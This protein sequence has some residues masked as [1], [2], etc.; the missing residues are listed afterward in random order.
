MSDQLS[1]FDV[2][3]DRVSDLAN[4]RVGKIVTWGIVGVTGIYL[5]S[6]LM[7]LLAH[8]VRSAKTL[9]NALKS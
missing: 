2:V 3:V 4:T 6:H 7:I 5:S 1:T 8:W 9:R